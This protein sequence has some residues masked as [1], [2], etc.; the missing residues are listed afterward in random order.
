MIL[1]TS[2]LEL[3]SSQ[4]HIR[5]HAHLPLLYHVYYWLIKALVGNAWAGLT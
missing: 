4:P 3:C 5:I 2:I 1:P